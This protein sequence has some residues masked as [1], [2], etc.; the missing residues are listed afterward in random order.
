MITIY[1]GSK[2]SEKEKNAVF[3]EFRENQVNFDLNSQKNTSKW[4]HENSKM[5]NNGIEMK[6]S[7]AFFL[8]IAWI[9]MNWEQMV[10]FFKSCRIWSNLAESN[11]NYSV[12]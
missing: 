5:H 10:K 11:R 6:L 3:W 7:L 8:D 1:K 2:G 9:Q 4:K 12:I